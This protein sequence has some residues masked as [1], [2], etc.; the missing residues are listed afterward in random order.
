ML[1]RCRIRGRIPNPKVLPQQ[2]PN[3]PSFFKL[4]MVL[5]FDHWFPGQFFHHRILGCVHHSVAA[6][7]PHAGV[8]VLGQVREQSKFRHVKRNSRE[9]TE[10]IVERSCACRE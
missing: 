2:I 4:Q 6:E 1:R 3:Q 5:R 9:F 8:D 10:K 7:T